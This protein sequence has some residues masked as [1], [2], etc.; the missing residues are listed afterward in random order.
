MGCSK[1]RAKE[2]MHS[3]KHTE[4]EER[5][6]INNITVQLNELEKNNK[7]N[8]NLAE[9]KKIIKIRTDINKIEK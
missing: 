6:Q 7:L 3:Y 5:L 1:S 4:T 9:G 2:E 8:P